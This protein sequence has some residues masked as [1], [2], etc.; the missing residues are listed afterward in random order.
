MVKPVALLA[1]G[2]VLCLAAGYAG[3]RYAAPARVEERERVVE[4]VIEVQAKTK[5]QSSEQSQA[6]KERIV[7]KTRYVRTP[8]GTV[9]KTTEAETAKEHD[10]HQAEAKRETE[11]RYVD[12][13]K[14]VEKLKIVER[15]QPSWGVAVGAGLS[16]GLRP[17]Y[18]GQVER[19]IL[20]GL[21]GGVYATT[22]RE[23]GVALRL[24][25]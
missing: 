16:S 10:S 24:E 2:G 20:G 15:A 11:I 7:Y 12:R 22:A 21:W 13:V 25:F 6:S 1:T 14:E 9:I 8:D 5:E 4:K 19:R 3:G 18:R 17:V 23:A